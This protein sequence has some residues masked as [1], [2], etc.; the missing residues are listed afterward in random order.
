MP[1]QADRPRVLAYIQA[2]THACHSYALEGRAA[3]EAVRRAQQFLPAQGDDA[4]RAWLLCLEAE[5]LAGLGDRQAAERLQQAEDAFHRP[6]PH[7][8]RAWTRFLDT[9]RMAAFQ[10]SVQYDWATNDR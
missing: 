2:C 7:R 3:L 1:F 4:T 9:G 6:R 10:L 8:E 5:Y